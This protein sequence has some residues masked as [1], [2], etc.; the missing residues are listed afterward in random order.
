MALIPKRLIP[1][2]N[3]TVYTLNKITSYEEMRDGIDRFYK[4]EFTK[5]M[6]LDFTHLETHLSSE[7]VMKIGQQMTRLAKTRNR[8]FDL[9]VVPGL[10]QYGLGRMYAAYVENISPE[11]LQTKVFRSFDAAIK[12]INEN[13]IIEKNK[14]LTK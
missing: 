3:A 10:L 14:G 5:Y 8:G 7:E 9:I 2:M 4:G 1:E 12:W 6:I 11:A 13:E